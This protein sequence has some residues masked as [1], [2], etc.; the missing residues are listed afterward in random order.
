MIHSDGKETRVRWTSDD[1][2]NVLCA[3]NP[4]DAEHV[5]P[6]KID[7][8]QRKA[9]KP[10]RRVKLSLLRAKLS[11]QTSRDAVANYFLLPPELRVP[12]PVVPVRA[13]ADRVLW[14]EDEWSRVGEAVLAIRPEGDTRPIACLVWHVSCTMLPPERMR[15]RAS[16]DTYTDAQYLKR[17]REATIRNFVAPKT[18][19]PASVELAPIEPSFSLKPETGEVETL[20]AVPAAEPM[21]PASTQTPPAA[22]QTSPPFLPPVVETI[23][24]LSALQRFARGF[25]GMVDELV[26]S[27]Q[28]EQAQQRADF[29]RRIQAALDQQRANLVRDIALSLGTAIDARVHKSIEIELGGPVSEAP[30]P[31]REAMP[32]ANGNGHSNGNGHALQNGNGSSAFEFSDDRPTEPD[33]PETDEDRRAR[34]KAETM[35]DSRIHLDRREETNTLANLTPAYTPARERFKVDAVGFSPTIAKEVSAKLGRDA[36]VRFVDMRRGGWEPR[37]RVIVCKGMSPV[38]KL[39]ASDSEVK[40]VN[41]GSAFQVVNAVREWMQSAAH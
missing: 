40:V 23:G 12:L 27:V 10:A 29:E 7:K 21:P 24:Q 22:P 30:T 18:E 20:V 17:F 4:P 6:Q 9:F 33:E 28:R 38:F 13:H 36:D 15:G 5:T 35:N 32:Y 25:A 1:W 26:D 39:K 11:S 16:L 41:N 19:Q 31:A 2:H 14:T 37:D 8:A 34:V 3:L